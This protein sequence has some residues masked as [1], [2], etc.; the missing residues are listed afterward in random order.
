MGKK[1]GA[2]QTDR[3]NKSTDSKRTERKQIEKGKEIDRPAGRQRQ[4][5]RQT[6]DGH[7]GRQ[8]GAQADRHIKTRWVS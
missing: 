6:E 2:R 7:T 5:D 4:T 1:A 3:Q 8:A